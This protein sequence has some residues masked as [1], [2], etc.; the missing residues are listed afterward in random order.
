MKV[1]SLDASLDS[2]IDLAQHKITDSIYNLTV[3]YLCNRQT[4]PTH[5]SFPLSWW[6]ITCSPTIAE[7]LFGRISQSLWSYLVKYTKDGVW[8]PQT[9]VQPFVITKTPIVLDRVC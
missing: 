5:D 3:F 2:P 6:L 1:N 7:P 8:Y 4:F 9:H